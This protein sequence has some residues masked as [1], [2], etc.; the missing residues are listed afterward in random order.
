[1]LNCCEATR[2]MSEAR[3]RSLSLREKMA[4]RFHTMICAACRRFNRQLDFLR[5]VSK[6]YTRRV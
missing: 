4:L 1:M 5:K 3:E 2:L 6:T